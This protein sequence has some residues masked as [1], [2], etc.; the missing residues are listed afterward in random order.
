MLAKVSLLW[1]AAPGAGN[2]GCVQSTR[3]RREEVLSTQ[4]LILGSGIVTIIDSTGDK[5]RRP[6]GKH[7]YY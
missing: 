4:V 7:Y 5:H 1:L 3:P 6:R 2:V